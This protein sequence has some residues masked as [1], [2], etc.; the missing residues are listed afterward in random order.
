MDNVSTVTWYGQKIPV[1][2]A[3]VSIESDTGVV[4]ETDGVEAPTWWS[5]NAVRIAASK[6][7]T[8]S[9][10]NIE[11]SILD[12]ITRVVEFIG[13][14]A[15]KQELIGEE[16]MYAYKC[17]LANILVNQKASF[18][19]PVWFNVGVSEK[20]QTS[21]CFINSVEDTMESIMDLAKTEAMLFKWGSGTGTN[22][23][24]IRS[25]KERVHGGGLA[26]GPVS[27]MKGLDSFANVIKSG[28]KTRRAAKMCILN[29][30][31][32]DIL[33]F[34]ESK[35]TEEA[36]AHA[37]ISQGYDGSLNGDAYSSVYFQNANHSIRVTDE[38]M[39]AV[40]SGGTIELVGIN[41]DGVIDCL[42]AE[43]ILD[44][45]ARAAWKCGDPGI[46]FD[47]EIQ[48]WHTCSHVEP[49]YASNPCSEFL[50]LD[51]TACNLASI[52]LMR[53]SENNNIDSDFINQKDF[54][55]R[56]F[57]ETV[58]IMIT[59]QEALVNVSSY[60][61]ERIEA[62]SHNYRPLGLGFTN[63][64]AYLMSKG[65]PYNSNEARTFASLVTSLMTATA[66]RQSAHLAKKKG[67]FAGYDSQAMLN[68]MHMHRDATDDIF[69][70]KNM[71]RINR[72]G[73][74][75]QPLNDWI[76][77]H[78]MKMW[79][80]AIDAGR[81][82]G[83]R[84]AQ[85]TVIAPTGTISFMMDCDSTGI[86]PLLALTTRKRLA[87]GGELII[88]NQCVHDGINAVT[89]VDDVQRSLAMYLENNGSFDGAAM[90]E[91]GVN[92]EVF[93]TSFKHS[94]NGECLPPLAHV[95]M[96]AA[97]QPFVSGSIS[98]TVNVPSEYTAED[99]KNIYIAAWNKKL[100]CIAVYRD[101]SKLVQPISVDKKVVKR[102]PHK[103]EK[104]FT[105]EYNRVKLP[106]TRNAVTH[107]A[108][109][110]D[111]ECYIT[112]GEYPDKRPGELFITMS[113]QGSTI[114]GL[115]DTIGILTSMGL[116]AGIPVDVF[117]TKLKHTKFEPSGF[118]SNKEIP[119]ATSVVDYIFSWI[120]NN[121]SSDAHSVP[122]SNEEAKDIN[123]NEPASFTVETGDTCS[124]C[125]SVLYRTGTCYTCP[126]CGE[127]G[128]CG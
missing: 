126:C 12:M 16:R 52:N 111:S 72:E 13:D 30:N 51:N 28:G 94:E 59:A 5:D 91:M 124:I 2:Y 88:G 14:A 77:E 125:G 104:K 45:A 34:I 58:K 107:R 53:F 46:Q 83:F 106:D 113:K 92:K 27:F 44:E 114:S 17:D 66:Y 79:D 37:L 32:P 57:V 116:Q 8:Q 10:H 84:N 33:D 40:E 65:I 109:I 48:K 39:K 11:N 97:V 118:T 80:R 18:N 120:S 26:S 60:P 90:R 81:D 119:T 50:F 54:D 29:A 67:A 7:F 9:E 6:Y 123:F 93:L 95:D 99:I 108:S 15:C 103:E 43:D 31:H 55:L 47:D 127:A 56:D 128:G 98:K 36:K 70:Y 89:P 122:S 1:R 82:Y 24:T 22:F 21:A 38:F 68:V 102:D 64:G 74:L 117:T 100:K 112:V 69:T 25:S 76:K 75:V 96:V 73:R 23:S 86:E 115:L 63:L 35:S 101:G 78:A 61:T 41:E 85:A 62:M 87:G 19:S 110:G 42:A 4:F 3:D 105:S 71:D 49:I 20:P 121:Y